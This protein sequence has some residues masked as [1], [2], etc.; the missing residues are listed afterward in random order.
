MSDA[1]DRPNSDNE[2]T[3]RDTSYSPGS[4]REMQAREQHPR[5]SEALDDDDI[6]AGDVNVLPGTGGPDD[7]GDVDVDEDDLN[8][9]R[10]P[11]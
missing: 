3:E 4:E 10:N 11:S 6:D 8:M 9:P 2:Q 7:V 5:S 1:D